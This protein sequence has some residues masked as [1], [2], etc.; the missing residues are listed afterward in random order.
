MLATEAS[1]TLDAVLAS[2]TADWEIPPSHR[3]LESRNH[4]H[5]NLRLE[6]AAVPSNDGGSVGHLVVE[7]GDEQV[8]DG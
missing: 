5:P 8:V 6:L 1:Q 3:W 7:S 2:G 4:S